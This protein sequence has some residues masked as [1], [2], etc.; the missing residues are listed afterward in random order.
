MRLLFYVLILM[1]AVGI[2]QTFVD[3]AI[4]LGINHFY[5]DLSPTGGVSFYDFN[6]D[7]WD[8]L[9]FAT[10][11]DS[12]IQF[13]INRD[14]T[15]EKINLN[16][17]NKETVMQILWADYDN[18]GDQDLYVN[19]YEGINRLY[20]NQGDL[21]FIDVTEAS[22]LPL[23]TFLSYG[24][25]WGDYN[26]DGYLDLYVQERK[27]PQLAA[28]NR[29]RLYRNNGDGTF[30]EVT[31]LSNTAALGK[32]PFCAAFA[33][34]NNDLWPDLYIAND[35]L[36][37]NTLLINQGDG[38]FLDAG[39]IS[40]AEPE[41]NAMC[42]AIGDYDSDGWQ[43]I[44]ITNTEEG[45]QLLR[46]EGTSSSDQPTFEDVSVKTGTDFGG[47]GWGSNFLDADN[48]GDLDLYVSGM[49]V[50]LDVIT[51]GLYENNGSGNF[52]KRPTFDGDTVISHS[53]AIGDVNNDGYPDIA[54]SNFVPYPAQLWVNQGA[55]NNWLKIELQGV[56]SNRDGIGSKI[57]IFHGSQYQQR[58]TFCGI[59]FLGQNSKT[60]IFGTGSSLT[61]DSIIITW[62]TG[63]RDKLYSIATN[64]KI[65]IVEGSTTNGD[66][67]VDPAIEQ[68]TT[69]TR[70][71]T[72]KNQFRLHVYPNPNHNHLMI[73]FEQQI[74]VHL[75]IHG[76]SGDLMFHS[77]N[78]KTVMIINTSHWPS[79]TYLIS[80]IDQK[81]HRNSALWIKH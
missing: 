35:K 34:F 9:T 14:G 10:D 18:D 20:Q 62:P 31:D 27:G 11:Q 4:Q 56:V 52:T 37:G 68:M 44:Y 54:V 51:S 26:R 2:T 59:G 47:I 43:D 76:N 78:L 28:E 39:T 75:E 15:Y 53:N 65:Q 70:A 63:H 46:N 3:S 45:N 50:G 5:S 17:D 1:P 40:G 80:I 19:A 22:G 32:K 66:I 13:Y 36:T 67:F 38:T 24:A 71:S 12:L 61:I 69:A 33:D 60:E 25:C 49:Q 29:N 74:P 41:M 7:G 64:Q 30:T 21:Q 55:E 72:E 73:D 58:L 42:V 6:D 57:E 8:D 79:G 81:G 48:D 23:E 77:E 16:I